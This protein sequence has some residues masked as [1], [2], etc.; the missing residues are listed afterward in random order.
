MEI[1][2]MT[3]IISI[4]EEGSI[5]KAAE[6]LYMTQSALNQQLLKLERELGVSLFDRRGRG[7]TPTYAGKLYL[8]SAR[9]IVDIRNATYKMLHDVSN[10]TRG[11]IS[12][13][14]TAE[15]GANMFTA[16]YPHFHNEYPEFT[17]NVIETHIIKMEQ[18]L[19]RKQ[20]ALAM[21]AFTEPN[22]LLVYHHTHEENL[23]LAVPSSHQYAHLAGER[24]GETLPMIDLKLFEHDDF[25]LMGQNTL[26]R[27]MC[28]K[29]FK[30]AGFVPNVLFESYSTGTVMKMVVNQMGPGFIPASFINH[31]APVVYFSIAENLQWKLS[32]ASLKGE[33][34]NQA[35][36]RFIEL[37]EQM[38]F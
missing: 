6:K 13:A 5:S 1:K 37:Y 29:A 17:F 31:S 16:I 21:I 24:S 30:N 12:L 11:E 27:I 14:Y 36:R 7:V 4:A 28:S 26:S 34:L 35:E 3:N 33:Y 15:R 10:E 18:L 19:E 9:K 8:E 23:V 2:Q 22:P 32:I 25:I 20:V 38:N